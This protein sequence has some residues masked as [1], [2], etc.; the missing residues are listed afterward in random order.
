[1]EF[2]VCFLK[3]LHPNWWELRWFLALWELWELFGLQLSGN[4]SF[5]EVVH[6]HPRPILVLRSFTLYLH[7]LLFSQRLRGTPQISE[8]PSLGSSSSLVCYPVSLPFF[9][10][11]AIFLKLLCPSLRPLG[12]GSLFLLL[13][14][15]NCIQAENQGNQ[16]FHPV[17]FPLSGTIILYLPVFQ[18]LKIITS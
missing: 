18:G 6:H 11:S 15:A 9:F 1:M 17:C 4:C 10:K 12:S 5:L 8:A 7:R 13:L 2:L 16:R 3:P 14:S